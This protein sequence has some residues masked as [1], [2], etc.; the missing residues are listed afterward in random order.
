MLLTMIMLLTAEYDDGDGENG[1]DGYDDD[2]DHD[3]D[4]NH[5]HSAH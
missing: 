4:V 5:L 1:C 2:G 3:V